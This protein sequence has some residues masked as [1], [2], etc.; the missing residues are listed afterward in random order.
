MQ[1]LFASIALVTALTSSY[2]DTQLTKPLIEILA[3]GGTIAGVS[4]SQTSATYKAGTLTA[5]QLLSSVPGLDKL[6]RLQVEQVFNKDSGDLTIDDW[7]ALNTAVNKA[8]NNPRVNGIVITH[9]TDTLE[10]TAYFLNLVAKT[11]KP[12]VIVGAMRPAT[13]ISADGPLNLYDALAVATNPAAKNA[14]VLVTMNERIFAARGVGKVNTTQVNA[15]IN[16]SNGTLGMVQ[17]GSVQF[18]Y[19]TL[20]PHTTATPFSV[21]GIKQLPKVAIVYEYAGIDQDQLGNLLNTKDL[22]G[23]VIAGMGD[24]NIP[25]Y[26]SDFLIKA[27]SKGIVIVR[28]SRVGSG[29]VS[30]DYNNLDSTYN[31]VCGNDLSPQQARIL[32][33]LSL[34][35]TT[36]VKQIQQYFNTY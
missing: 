35:K 16:R 4:S 18:F 23:I 34:L 13:S 2:A 1:K 22:K 14:G 6:A 11:N 21:A 24:G 25:N 36:D 15:F 27:R 3:T 30:Y 9:G 8:A 17:L 28:S 5:E 33:M 7:L 31:L 10:E 26:E 12:I 32:L 29:K 20:M 19:K